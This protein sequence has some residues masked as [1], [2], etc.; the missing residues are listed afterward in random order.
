MCAQTQAGFFVCG[1]LVLAGCNISEMSKTI[2]THIAALFFIN[3]RKQQ[4]MK[5]GKRSRF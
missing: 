5:N 2:H 3:S 4:G 1:H